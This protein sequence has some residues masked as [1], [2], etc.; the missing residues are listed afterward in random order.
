MFNCEVLQNYYTEKKRV[1]DFTTDMRPQA[2][3]L[4]LEVLLK[5]VSYFLPPWPKVHISLSNYESCEI[6]PRYL[7]KG[8]G[9]LRR[10]RWK[11]GGRIKGETMEILWKWKC[12]F[13]FLHLS[14]ILSVKHKY[15]NVFPF[16][17]VPHSLTK[18]KPK[19]FLKVFLS[20]YSSYLPPLFIVFRQ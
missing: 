5:E 9:S 7:E 16:T 13:L 18:N 10:R 1:S 14:H 8:G 15:L 2:P 17:T 6:L 19:S 11:D 3:L 4:L 20:V 12:W